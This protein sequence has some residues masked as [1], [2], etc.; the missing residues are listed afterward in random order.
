M[1]GLL[2]RFIILL[3]GVLIIYSLFVPLIMFEFPVPEQNVGGIMINFDM[4]MESSMYQLGEKLADL[5]NQAL[6]KILNYLWLIFLGL[7]II[8][9]L[10]AIKPHMFSILRIIFA[11]MPLLL[12]AVVIQQTVTNPE[13]ELTYQNMFEYFVNGFYM[14]LI[15]CCA[16]VLGAFLIIRKRRVTQK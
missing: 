8:N 6:P 15:G 1:I 4:Q 12:L 10:I 2:G 9:M 11:V 3:A 14:L 5:E 13:L 16:M 7:T